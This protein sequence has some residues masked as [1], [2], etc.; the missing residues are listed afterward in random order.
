V[1]KKLSISLTMGKK[2]RTYGAFRKWYVNTHVFVVRGSTGQRILGMGDGGMG[3]LRGREYN[4][5]ETDIIRM[6]IRSTS[7][8]IRSGQ[9][10]S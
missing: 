10:P 1:K 9:F 6:E 2:S 4:N 7:R 3:G 8:G 5:G